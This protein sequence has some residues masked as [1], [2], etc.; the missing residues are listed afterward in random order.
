[1]S[2]GEWL[3]RHGHD[4]HY[5]VGQTTQRKLPNIHSLSKNIVV[6][7]NGNR[8]D[9][10]LYG[11]RRE[12]K[13]LMRRERFDVL[14]VQTPHHPLLAQQIILQASK[15]TAIVAT[16]HILP[17]GWFAGIA[18][19]ALG[20]LLRPSLKRIEAMLAV[21]PVAAEFER[22][23]FGPHVAVPPEVLPNVFDQTHFRSAKPFDRY[24]DDTLTILSL[25]RLVPRKG[26]QLLLEAVELLHHE[27][28][29]PR[30]RVLVCGRGPLEQ[31]LRNFVRQR[32]L[33]DIVEF[34]GFVSNEDKPRYYASADISVFPSSSGESFGIVLL[35]AMASGSSAVLAGDNPGYRSVMEPRP[36]TLFD[37]N[38]A[39]ALA[40]RLRTLM[41]QPQKRQDLADWGKQYVNDFDVAV[42][43]KKLV[44]VYRRLLASKNVR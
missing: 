34:C 4:V 14:H 33:D 39:A 26:C 37:P 2:V 40:N 20:L 29:V 15:Q 7:F 30:F 19:R 36:E 12:I 28:D 24:D 18:N 3:R 11:K 41:S 42:V 1:M 31:S 27:P 8:V 9:L 16:F 6:T 44:A 38:D 13:E 5:L 23:T 10:P 17:Y 43:G 22:Q 35:E 32:S 25:G 21:T